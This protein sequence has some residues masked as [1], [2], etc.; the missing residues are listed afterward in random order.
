MKN[1]PLKAGFYLSDGSKCEFADSKQI[2]SSKYELQHDLY[3]RSKNG[4]VFVVKKGFVHDGASKGFLKR[5][6]K[7]TNAAILHDALYASE[8]L[9]RKESDDLFLEA[10][11]VSD[12]HYL[13]R[14]TYYYAVRMFGGFV[15]AKH[16][17]HEIRK[18]KRYILIKEKK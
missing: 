7:Y 15:W 16:K 4:R 11:E 1:I 9:S 14:Y 18:A 13:R 10:M 3:Y 12:V 5:F 8:L 2:S 17:R 6:G